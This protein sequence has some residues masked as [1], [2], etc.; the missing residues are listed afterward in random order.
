MKFSI[1]RAIDKLDDSESMFLVREDDERAICA[2]YLG[3]FQVEAMK[4]FAK[5]H[6]NELWF[7]KK[8]NMKNAELI[9]E[10]EI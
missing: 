9:E 7:T 2:F 8:S 4:E 3:D 5:N 1:Y 6:E 10:F